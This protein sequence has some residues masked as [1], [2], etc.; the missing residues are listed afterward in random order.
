MTNLLIL[1]QNNTPN[2]SFI[3]ILSNV[4]IGIGVLPFIY[5]IFKFIEGI[6]IDYA[7]FGP[8]FRHFYLIKRDLKPN[9]KQILESSFKF[10]RQLNRKEQTYFRHRVYRYMSRVEFVGREGLEIDDEKKI[11]VS[12][13]AIMLTF[14]YRNY[15]I[16]L[17]D[18]ILIYP[19]TFYSNI[20]KNYH[21][22]HFNPGFRAIIIS[23][24]DFKLG[25]DIEDDN[26]NL[27]IHEFV[28]A[29]H[30]GYLHD[31]DNETSAH[32]FIKGLEELN[33]SLE[34]NSLDKKKMEESDYFRAYAFENNFEFIAVLIETF[35]ETP[36]QFKSQFP[37]V[38]LKIKQM[39]NFNFVGY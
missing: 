13:T 9:Q 28:H 4:L 8:L 39:L 1:L 38:Y 35:I 33:S 17:V 25:Y 23:W 31:K 20:D 7:G 16:N 12:A 34:S 15:N 19:S 21:K 32:L 6:L 3:N 24:E 29:L 2:S 22:G 37:D 18:R 11:L 36:K 10:Y 30:I 27:G 14:G 26:L 5:L